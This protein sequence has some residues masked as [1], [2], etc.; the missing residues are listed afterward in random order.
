MLG[1]II[2]CS[3]RDLFF[4]PTCLSSSSSS[5]ERNTRFHGAVCSCQLIANLLQ[6][7]DD[8]DDDDCDDDINH[9]NH[10]GGDN[11]GDSLNDDD[12]STPRVICYLR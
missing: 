1:D 9:D 10:N 8:D 5:Y 11:D 12:V 7:C 3:H 4:A 6:D 2:P